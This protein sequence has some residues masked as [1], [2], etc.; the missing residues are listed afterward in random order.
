MAGFN[1]I[2]QPLYHCRK[3]KVDIC[4]NCA[5]RC[6][7]G[8][9]LNYKGMKPNS[10]YYCMNITNCKFTERKD[11]VC[12][13]NDMIVECKAMEYPPFNYLTCCTN[14]DQ[15]YIIQNQRMYHCLTCGI[16]SNGQGICESCAIH[17]HIGHKVVF[18]WIKSFACEFAIMSLYKRILSCTASL[19]SQLNSDNNADIL[20]EFI[21]Y[22]C[23]KEKPDSTSPFKRKMLIISI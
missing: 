10:M 7:K 16:T 3:C 11:V 9:S 12:G 15:K 2:F 20:A 1:P 22:T 21:C 19:C 6:H 23:D 4:Q 18:I 13:A 5:I 8:H 14:R 17:C